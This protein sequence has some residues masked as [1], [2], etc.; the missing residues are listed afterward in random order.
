M[1]AADRS[2]AVELLHGRTA[3]YTRAEVVRPLLTRMGWPK[4]GAT[5]IDPSCGDGIFLECALEMLPEVGRD[6]HLQLAGWEVHTGAAEA[7][8]DRVYQV[9]CQYMS[10]RFAARRAEQMVRARDF[11]TDGPEERYDFVVGNPP[12]LRYTNVPQLLRM[13]YRE[14][15]PRYAQAD[16][17]HSFLDR[18]VDLVNPHGKIGFI[19][20]DR[21]LFNTSAAQLREIV[22]SRLAIEHLERHSVASAFYHAKTRRINTPPRVH[23]V[24]VVLAP[25]GATPLTAAPIYPGARLRVAGRTLSDVAQINQGPYLGTKGIFWMTRVKA[26]ELG[27][28]ESS[29]VPAVG[30]RDLRGLTLRTPEFVALL[31]Q[32]DVRPPEPIARHLL[33]SYGRMAK[34]GQ[35]RLQRWVPPESIEPFPLATESLVVPRILKEMRVLR[36]PAGIVPLNHNL[37]IVSASRFDLDELEALLL[38]QSTWEWI[39][40]RG[41][42]I[43]GGYYSITTNLLRELPI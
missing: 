19:T 9:L 3:I 17:L 22:G 1:Y 11:L 10:G 29:L 38:S 21:W 42:R 24:E 35:A 8:R 34:R 36:L 4:P 40:E 27:L 5:L 37:T 39:Q 23:P 30:P 16:L 25:T 18:C 31:T 6:I 28:P 12:Y 41:H 7:A 13:E 2:A 32:R 33:A 43:D 26:L 14:A 20:S 15:V